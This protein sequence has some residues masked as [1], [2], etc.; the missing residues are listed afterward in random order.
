MNISNYEFRNEKG[1]I[2]A[3]ALITWEECDR[4]PL[5]LFVQTI[6]S[7]R[8]ALWPDPNSFLIATILTAWNA[9]ERR[10]RLNDSVCP[11]LLNN[12]EG[13][14]MMLKSWYPD[15]F[16]PRPEIE[17]AVGAKASLPVGN[18][19]IALMSGGID[20]LCL[21]RANK[22]YYPK[23]HPNSIKAVL[24]ITH[25]EHLAP[26]QEALWKTFEGRM[27]SISPVAADAKVDVIPVYT[28]MW[29]LNPD[30]YFF[31]QKSYS[32]QLSAVSSFFARSFHKGYIASS[33]DAAFSNKP[34][35]SHPQLDAYY[36]SGHF[37][38]ENSGTEMTRLKKVA[39]V[40]DWPVGF[41]SMRV[42][43]NDNTG[44][45]NCGTCEKCIRTMLMLEALGKLRDCQS[46][47]RNTIDTELL[48]YLETYDMLHS[49]DIMHDAEKIYLYEMTIPYLA[50]R[51]RY[52]L[53]ETLKRILLPLQVS[54]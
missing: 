35:G 52:D 1:T 21:L 16:G 13:V 17:A 10:I 8:D 44:S 29:W 14:F 50:E 38:M 43:Q 23:S 47:P 49:T 37:Q 32:S 33:Y 31:G 4:P 42:C 2:R 39:L 3:E 6:D 15:G 51:G 20:S 53:V 27:T 24:S 41:Q 46:F 28:N 36:T 7:Y 48:T 22:L 9:G 18:G 26:D 40:A 25:Q 11:V 19:A 30:G 12:L 54:S 5:F 34:W 45:E